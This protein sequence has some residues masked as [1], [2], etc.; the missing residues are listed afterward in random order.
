[1]NNPFDPLNDVP[2]R[3]SKPKTPDDWVPIVPVPDDAPAPPVTHFKRG[4]PGATWIYRDAT[5]KLL[6]VI[7]RFDT[8]KG[9]KDFLPFTYCRNAASQKSEW[10]NKSWQTPRPLYNLDQ[11]ARRRDV[12]IIVC[13]GEKAADAAARLCP[14]MVAV[15]SAGGA[16]AAAKA[17]W[18]PLKGRDVVIWPDADEPGKAYADDVAKQLRKI[19]ALSVATLRPSSDLADGFDAADAEASKWTETA[20]KDFLRSAELY[21]ALGAA[22]SPKAQDG[23]ARR[24]RQSDAIV[25]LVEDSDADLWIDQDGE[26]FAT[27]PINGHREN[28]PLRSREFR[29][30]VSGRHYLASG[31]AIGSQAME[32]SFRV[33]EAK[34]AIEGKTY[35]TF[36][37][38][39]AVGDKIYVDRCNS[40]WQAIE[41]QKDGWKAVDEAKCKFI[42]GPAMRALPEPEGGGSIDELRQFVN[43]GTDADFQLVVSWLVGALRPKGPFPI[44]CVNGEQGSGKS[45]LSRLLRELTDP[46]GS[47][48]RSSPEK[49]RDL[50][51][52]AHNSWVLGLDN[53]SNV[54]E[55]LSDALCR[56]ATGGGFSAR[57]LHADRDE[58]YF[59]LT[60]PIMLNGIPALTNRP[61]LADRALTIFL[62]NIPE[63]ERRTESQFWADF[64]NAKPRILGALLDGVCSAL[65]NI[66]KVKL[67]RSPRMADFAQ[68]ATAAEAGLGWDPGSFIDAYYDNRREMSESSFE[69]D[70]LA[71]AV[72]TFVRLRENRTFNGTMTELLPLLTDSVTEAVRKSRRWPDN[73][74]KLGSNM[75]RIY[76][77]L[78]AR[79]YTIE[80]RHSGYRSVTI[81]APPLEAG[82]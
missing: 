28:W 12:P 4:K 50:F 69:A 21:M 2:P 30:W 39:G 54:A 33:L 23:R 68:W 76:P 44:L 22:T 37:R 29:R 1:M 6:G 34:A 7:M 10:R 75:R 15:T 74:T 77:L 62:R 11:V 73:A 35:D 24:P 49:D 61:D 43:V 13:E 3:P 8:G 19:G 16:K 52:M 25:S 48:L 65:R 18:T 81:I 63:T 64:E 66:S 5:G 53:L 31:G 71:V 78:R 67:E 41:V 27:I 45:I 59:N 46:N 70:P 56:I 80:H 79:G 38:I 14:D 9:E 47:P 32:D 82:G 26:A 57:T 42:R 36:R 60:R 58:T 72:D 51:V 20:L 55:W 17:D 40:A